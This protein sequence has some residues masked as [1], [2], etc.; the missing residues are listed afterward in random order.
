MYITFCLCPVELCFYKTVLYS[1]QDMSQANSQERYGHFVKK[2]TK[3]TIRLWVIISTQF[4][5]FPKIG[6]PEVFCK[7]KGVL[8]NFAKFIG[9]HLSQSLFSNKVTGTG[10]FIWHLWNFSE[11]LFC[12]ATPVA[13]SGKWFSWSHFLRYLA[14]MQFV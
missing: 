3:K 8:K 5:V 6:S 2:Q 13:V 7:K 9:K 10:L 4:Q 1:Q 11:H 14:Y 12:R